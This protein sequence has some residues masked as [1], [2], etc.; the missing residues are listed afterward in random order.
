[1]KKFIF[2]K[3]TT[4]QIAVLKTISTTKKKRNFYKNKMLNEKTGK[5]NHEKQQHTP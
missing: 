3:D 1:M 4:N 5:I 2:M